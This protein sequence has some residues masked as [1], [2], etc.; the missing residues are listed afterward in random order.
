VKVQRGQQVLFDGPVP[1]GQTTPPGGNPL[2]QPWDGFVKLTTL[3][4]QVAIAVRLYPDAGAYFRSLQTGVPQPMTEANAPFMQYEVW[5]GKLLDNSL[6]SLDTRF[7]RRTSSG[8]IGK[9][10]TVD[11]D[12]RLCGLGD[13]RPCRHRW[14]T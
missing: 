1:L 13:E 10:W 9:G 2:A 3:R 11:A 5:Q 6:A 7:M 14:R 12:P 8:L 4:P